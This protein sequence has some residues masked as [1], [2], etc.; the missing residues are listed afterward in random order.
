MKRDVVELEEKRGNLYIAFSLL[1][2]SLYSQGSRAIHLIGVPRGT[3]TG[4]Y[5][6]YLGMNCSPQCLL[7]SQRVA[8]RA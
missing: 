2:S 6:A 8:F 5:G 7:A 4:A 3:A 1:A